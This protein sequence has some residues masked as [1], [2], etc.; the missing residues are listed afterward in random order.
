M[1]AEVKQSEL[2]RESNLELQGGMVVNRSDAPATREV[3]TASGCVER[4]GD[5]RAKVGASVRC[6]CAGFW[7]ECCSVIRGETNAMEMSLQSGEPTEVG[8]MW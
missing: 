6:A 5:E 3:V 4:S 8:R 7:V 2:F 1:R